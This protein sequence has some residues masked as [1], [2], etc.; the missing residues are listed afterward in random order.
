MIVLIGLIMLTH[1]KTRE[2]GKV[3]ILIGLTFTLLQYIAKV[4]TL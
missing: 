1:A 2:A 4:V 3:C